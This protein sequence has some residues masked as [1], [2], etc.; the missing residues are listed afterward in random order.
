MKNRKSLIISI[1]I[2]AIVYAAVTIM[3]NQGMLSRQMMS[4]IVPICVYI[5]LAVSLSL[6]VG[7]LGEL[8]LGHAG[9]MSVG[10]YSGALFLINTQD[11][12]PAIVSLIGALLI[13]GCC[14]AIAGVIIGVPVLRLKGDYL[15]IVTLGFGEIIKSVINAME[16][17]GGAKGLSKIPLLTTYRSFT[18]VF[19]LVLI[20]IIV[21]AN[22]VNSRHGRAVCAVRD[23][24]IATEAVGI[25]VSRFKIMAF[26]VAA[27][28]AGMAGVV[29]AG[30]IGILKPSQFDYN[31]SI[32]ILV[33]VV[34]G[35][36]ANI[37]GVII[38]AVILTALPEVL[39][40]A[41]DYRMLLYAVVLIIM[42]LFNNS[43]IK[44]RIVE[45]RNLR[46]AEKNE[47]E[48]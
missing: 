4:I 40:G 12:L 7:F 41:S 2:A 1:I 45:K 10:A 20:V 14:A 28:L 25:P 42:M 26:V 22:L 43:L 46:K 13:G 19:I 17:T 21:V 30:N 37:K 47:K 18:I 35:G 36:M 23:N 39:R 8:S 31:M 34:L 32:E 24:D 33:M 9:F 29:Y 11:S 27:F 44:Q 15:A 16:I 6:V 5:M 3:V 38:A 48:A